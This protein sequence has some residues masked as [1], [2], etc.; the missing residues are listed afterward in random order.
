MPDGMMIDG[1]LFGDDN[2]CFGCGPSHPFGFHLQ[3]KIV[4]EGVVATLVP[5]EL[6]QG[7]PGIM[8]GGLVCT[9]ADEIGAWALIARTGKFGFTTD[10]QSRFRRPV[11]TGVET[12]AEAR[13]TRDRRRLVDVGVTISQ[14][15]QPCY[16]GELT[17]VLLTQSAVEK[18]L[19]RPLPES[20]QRFAR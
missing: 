2:H 11:R 9:L 20:W 10:M 1:T 13:V 6:Y 3:A 4:D 5:K 15:G 7:A 17:F 19:G 16:V 18:L 12:I 14:E 8:H